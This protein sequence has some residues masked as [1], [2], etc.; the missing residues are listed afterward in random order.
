M[1]TLTSPLC[2]FLLVFLSHIPP[3][4][5]FSDTYHYEIKE[6]SGPQTY[7]GKIKTKPGF[8]YHFNDDPIEF[9]L[10]PDT[11]VILTTDVPVDRESRS[12]YNL[13]ILSSSPTYPI[14]VI[15]HVLDVNDNWPF[16]PAYINANISFSESAPIGTKVIIDNAIDLDSG[17]LQYRIESV[18]DLLVNSAYLTASA[19]PFKLNYNSSTSFLHLEVA[20]KL[21]REVQ[22]NY[23][24]N[25]TAFDEDN[26]FS[27]AI[28]NIRVLDSNDNPP[29]FDHSDYS[30]SLNESMG[31]DVSI[32][33]VRATD[34]DEENNDNSRISYYLNSDDFKIDPNTGVIYTAHDGPI[35]CGTTSEKMDKDYWRVCVFTVFAHDYGVPRQDG[36]TYVTAKIYDSNNNAPTIKFRY[37]SKSDFAN[38]DE[39]AINGSVVA[40]VF[41]VD[42]DPGLN[43]Q[44]WLEVASGNELGHFRLESIGNSHII[45]VNGVLDR[46]NVPHYNLTIIAHDYGTPSKSSVSNLIIMVQDH[47]DHAPKFDRQVYETTIPENQKQIGSFVY[48]V[49]ATDLDEGINSQIYYSLSGANS[50]YFKIDTTTGLITTDKFINREEIDFF[51]LRIT[52]RDG[53]SNP[54]WAH[55]LLKVKISDINDEIPSVELLPKYSFDND[56]FQY[57]VELEEG[58]FLD[59]NLIVKDNDLG[60]N[61]SVDVQILFDYDGI[62]KVDQESMKLVSTDKMNFELHDSYNVV[63]LATDQAPDG[64][65]L[66]SLTS[67]QIVIK[68]I[69]DELPMLFPFKHY[70]FISLNT[71]EL[72]NNSL[73]KLQV[74]DIDYPTSVSFEIQT[75]DDII[76]QLFQLTEFGEIRFKNNVNVRLLKNVP[77]ILTFDVECLG[78]KANYNSTQMNI[79]LLN[80]DHNSIDQDLK[81]KRYYQFTI[82]EDRPIGSLVGQ[83]NVDD[84]FRLFITEGD[85]DGQF[86]MTSNRIETKKLLDREMIGSYKLKVVAIKAN[87]FV[88]ID[89]DIDLI[90][91]NDCEPYFNTPYYTTTINDNAPPMFVVHRLK[92]IDADMATKNS[93]IEYNLVENPFDLFTIERNELK[94][95]RTIKETTNNWKQPTDIQMMKVRIRAV[96]KHISTDTSILNSRS[97]CCDKKCHLANELSLFVKVNHT[98][99][100]NVRFVK[101]FH[102]IF[103]SEAISINEQV[104]KLETRYT[105]DNSFVYSITSGNI[106][107]SFGIFPSGYLYVRNGLDRETTDVYLL[108]IILH[109]A[110]TNESVHVYDSCQLLIHIKDI[111]DNKPIFDKIAYQFSVPENVSD[112]FFVGQVS[113]SDKDM[114]LNSQIIFSIVKS[115]YSSFVEIDPYRGYI[116][117]NREYDRE[118]LSNFEIVVQAVD[119]S[120][121]EDRFSSQVTVRIDILDINDNKPI[122]EVPSNITLLSKSNNNVFGEMLVSESFEVSF[123]LAHFKANDADFE[124]KVVYKLH[125]AQ[126][127]SIVSLDP[128]T[129]VLSLVSKLD[130]ETKDSYKFVIEAFD[131]KYN[132]FFNLKLIIEDVDDCQPVWV[133]FTNT[134]FS[135]TENISIGSEIM[136]FD[137]VD[138]D[139]GSNALFHFEIANYSGNQRVFDILNQKLV[140]VNHLDYEKAKFHYLNI[141]LVET[142]SHHVAST[143][144]IKI[145][146]IDVNDCKPTFIQKSETEVVRVLENIDI[147]TKLLTLQAVDCDQNDVLTFEILSCNTHYHT[148]KN[149]YQKDHEL[150]HK[151]DSNNCP[152]KLNTKTGEIININNL[153][154]EVI[155][156]IN[157][158]LSVR[159]SVGHA[160]KMNVIFLIDDINDESPMFVSPTKIVITRDLIKP[161]MVIGSVKAID[162]DLGLNSAISYKLE[163]TQYEEYLQL[164]RYSGIFKTKKSLDSLLYHDLYVNVSAVD[165]GGLST[166][167]T[168]HFI[169]RPNFPYLESINIQVDIYENEPIGTQ[170]TKLKCHSH[171]SSCQFHLVNATDRNFLV[172]SSTGII[173]TVDLIDREMLEKRLLQV[174]VISQLNLQLIEVKFADIPCCM[175]KL[176]FCLIVPKGAHQHPRSE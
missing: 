120:I 160:D 98:Q 6:N 20:E 91:V 97:C 24:V 92:A 161:N 70:S 165:G 95:L 119:Q 37:F 39:N 80:T 128:Q 137:A 153:D 60:N 131:G 121:D 58:L 87:Y 17:T 109:K 41:V 96:D 47:N 52:A 82:E 49:Q 169:L 9:N 64:Q 105:E 54:K 150:Q 18:S 155:E 127:S 38:V 135:V 26:Q 141:S 68:D 46:E 51:E 152:L 31:K 62:F 146:L 2:L 147:G 117:T 3:L 140:V 139:L 132:S 88:L 107:N 142:I 29:I 86:G 40:A 93:L 130:R 101:K 77:S 151:H 57:K 162:L 94:L 35:I 166:T 73:H 134:E 129:G 172:D 19:L 44:T 170:V 103:I 12:V 89:V 164:D 116:W 13:V 159:D 113:A 59:L 63:L 28:F 67:I 61:G 30:V 78:C 123:V 158:K 11:G 154:R 118:N 42:F 48:T 90:D 75:K 7:V 173:M 5:C 163:S 125:N 133:N 106:Q 108:N 84:R 176:T 27:S 16:W 43:G 122:F 126:N 23:L 1:G 104:F 83:L 81:I 124:S 45:R 110:N 53:G 114:G 8:T 34:A 76:K 136:K 14:E 144:T 25:L 100:A 145:N 156:S 36:R 168:I 72:S 143:K 99:P 112:N 138:Y 79:F 148:H 71:W 22:S 167:D 66:S 174:L 69:D 21:D 10:D 55:A 115:Y 65:R 85:A 32:L 111:N 33:Q 74:K 149:I 157:L 50:H 175:N 171:D 102:E 15:I 56:T 4:L